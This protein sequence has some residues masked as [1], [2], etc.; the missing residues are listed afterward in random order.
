MT[1]SRTR[2]VLAAVTA[3]AALSAIGGTG[4]ASAASKARMADTAA[5]VPASARPAVRSGG[6]VSDPVRPV[7]GVV[8]AISGSGAT[9][10]GPATDE[11]CEQYERIIAD[12]ELAQAEAGSG[13]G[14]D[15]DLVAFYEEE[16][17]KTEDQGSDEGCFFI[18]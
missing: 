10:D 14:T 13:W 11:D 15:E 18:D 8:V 12:I 3:I 7:A 6:V 5:V 9:G 17:Q 2:S 16:K 1:H 4:L